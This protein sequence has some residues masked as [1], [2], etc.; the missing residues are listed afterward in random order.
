MNAAQSAVKPLSRTAS[1]LKKR[2]RGA[3]IAPRRGARLQTQRDSAVK[4]RRGA[5]ATQRRRVCAEVSLVT[6]YS[7][8][9]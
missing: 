4:P 2:R 6:F 9:E 5:L 1:N 7:P 3:A 8:A